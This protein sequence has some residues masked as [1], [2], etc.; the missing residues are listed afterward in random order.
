[1]MTLSATTGLR[2]TES[3]NVLAVLPGV[4]PKLRNEHI[5]LTAHLDHLGR[6]AAVN[7]DS[8]YN[9]AHDNALGVGILLEIAEALRGDGGQTATLH[10]VRRRHRGREGTA[11][12]R[13]SGESHGKLEDRRVVANINI[14]MPLLFAPVRDFVALGA[15]HSSL[16]ALARNAASVARLSPERRTPRRKK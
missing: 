10:R 13:L 2:R 15:E 14:D 4:D 12:F 7:G 3:A 16:G 9:G 5:V 11:R 6:G 1:M 8:I